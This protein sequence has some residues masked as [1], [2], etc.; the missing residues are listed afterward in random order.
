MDDYCGGHSETCNSDPSMSVSGPS[1]YGFGCASEYAA[2]TA[3][4]AWAVA[5]TWGGW[6][7][8]LLA[9][10]GVGTVI[11]AGAIAGIMVGTAAVTVRGA[12]NCYLQQQDLPD[13]QY[14][15]PLAEAVYH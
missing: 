6:S 15:V 5:T 11:A 4:V 10:S 14:G 13:D 3:T 1:A 12:W 8:A 9:S 2:S 7:L